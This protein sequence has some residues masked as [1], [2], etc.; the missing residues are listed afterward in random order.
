MRAARNPHSKPLAG[1]LVL[2]LLLFGCT[3]KNGQETADVERVG[4]DALKISSEAMKNLSLADA[5][6]SEFPEGLSVMGRISIPEDRVVVVPARVGGRIDGVNVASGEEVQAGRGLATIFSPDFAVA[7]EEYVQAMKQAGDGS[8]EGK[9]LAELARRKLEAIGLTRAD[10]DGIGASEA[11]GTPNLVVRAPRRGI[12]IDKKAVVG[13]FV[14]QGDTLFTL[15]DITK[16]WFAGD[17]YP[18]DLSKVRKDQEV[19]I[20]PVSGGAAVHGKVS[21][22]SPV[23][24]P[25][26]RTIKI[27]A[28]VENPDKTLRAD[29][30]VKGLLTLQK[31]PAIVVPTTAVVRARGGTFCFKKVEPNKFQRV[32]IIAGSERGGLTTVERGLAAGDQVV[33]EGALLLEGALQAGGS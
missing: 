16:V 30:Y 6:A 27:R 4:E 26:T 23:V 2:V 31:R 19:L 25:T 24:D 8:L 5:K 9:R 1:L 20:E 7:R 17:V 13:N 10:I 29:M 11:T 12:L 32:P 33:S 22:I 21:F 14:N 28:L 3:K 15:G 18:E